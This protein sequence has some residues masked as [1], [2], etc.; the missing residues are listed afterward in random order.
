MIRVMFDST[1]PAAIPADAGLVAGYVDGSFAWSDADWQ[2]FPRAQK[3]HICVTGDHTKGDCLDVEK[4]DATPGQAP[5]WIKARQAAGVKYAT[6]YCNRSNLAAVEKACA[7][8]HYYRWIATL[9][10]ILHIPGYHPLI[11]PAAVQFANSTMAGTNVDVSLVYEPGW[12]P[13]PP[14]T[15]LLVHKLQRIAGDIT[16]VA[17]DLQA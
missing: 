16:N 1:T 12:H 7:G 2:R 5:G 8:L 14:Q 9:D 13:A 10:G 17:R 4:G 3:I 6:I 11:G 15:A